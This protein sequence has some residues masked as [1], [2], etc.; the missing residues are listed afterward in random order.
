MRCRIGQSRR[1]TSIL[2]NTQKNM[3]SNRWF[4]HSNSL[5]SR[6]RLTAAATLLV[7]AGTM[8]FVALKSS[9]PP[10]LGKSDRPHHTMSPA[11]LRLA[12]QETLAGVQPGGTRSAV[13]PFHCQLGLS[14]GQCYDPYQM[15][16]AYQIDSLIAAGFDGT[17]HTIVIVDAF[18]NP[19]LVARWLST[20]LFTAFPR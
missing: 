10:L 2:L 7:A 8:A 15:R 3:K 20:T 18:Q 12:S 6:L 5:L 4:D 1:S 19:N 14:V 16:H 13:W 9:S 11:S 17:G